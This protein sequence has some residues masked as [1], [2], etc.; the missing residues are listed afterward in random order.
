MKLS[1]I[2]FFILLTM[3]VGCKKETENTKNSNKTATQKTDYIRPIKSMGKLVCENSKVNI[4]NV[5]KGQT[6]QQEFIFVNEGSET[7]E[8]LG[9]EKSCNCTDLRISKSVIKPLDSVSISMHIDTKEK[10]LGEHIVTVT[11]K[12]NGQRTFY[13]LTS[14]FTLD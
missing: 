6:I 4:G 9:Y 13:L 10:I 1:Q 14:N 12:T 8:V 11:I 5:K 2:L 7:V 3:I